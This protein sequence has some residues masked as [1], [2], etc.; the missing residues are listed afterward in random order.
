MRV[1]RSFLGGFLVLAFAVFIA[2]FLTGIM[3][4]AILG[5]SLNVATLGFLYFLVGLIAGLVILIVALTVWRIRKHEPLW[6]AGEKTRL[7]W[8]GLVLMATAFLA[9]FS[10]LWLTQYSNAPFSADLQ[11]IL[12]PLVIGTLMFIT[13]G[14]YMMKSG[15]KKPN[16]LTTP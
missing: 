12:I 9:L 14:L 15:V 6:F 16:K 2:G 10:G 8:F 3:A 1:D 13:M 7:F 4:I 5:F 11:R